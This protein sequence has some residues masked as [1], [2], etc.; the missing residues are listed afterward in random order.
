MQGIHYVILGFAVVVA[1]KIT[2]N[3]LAG[4]GISF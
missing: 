1:A 4:F 2:K 3:L